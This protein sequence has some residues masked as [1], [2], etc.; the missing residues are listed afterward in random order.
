MHQAFFSP[1]VSTLIKTI[2]NNQLR[3]IPMMKADLVQKYL[4]PS[5]ATSK[6]HMKRPRTGNQ[7]TGPTTTTPSPTTVPAIPLSHIPDYTPTGPPATTPHIIDTACNVF[8]YAAL[9]DKHQGTMYTDATGAL[10]A[11]TLEGNQYYFVAYAYDPNY[12]YATPLRNLR[13]ESITT[14]FNDIFQDL[15]AKGYKPTFN[16]TNNQATTPIK[17]YLHKEDCQWQFTE[18]NN[19]RVNAAERAIQTFK[20]H[21][22]SG[23]CSTD[24]D[25]PLQ[26]WDTLTEQALITLNLLRTSQID[27]SKS[28]YYQLHGHRYDWNAYSLAPPGTK[29][30]IY[31]SPTT[32]TSLGNRGL[33]AWYCGPAFDHYRNVK[34]Y[35]PSTK[36]FRVSGLYDL[37]PQH[38]I[39]P[40]LTPEQ[41]AVEVHKELFESIINTG[42]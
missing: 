33:D 7:S 25:W 41:H 17:A 28:A 2:N 19:H 23:L 11:V 4:A 39:L 42:T 27:P 32:R 20:N 14:A 13:D 34:F 36:A 9:A 35:V 3:G 15:K 29:A 21:F 38:C 8:C 6:G 12:I 40:T 26:L 37:F 1:P 22:V 30:I 24:C 16:V 10:P 5:P 18:P 31:E